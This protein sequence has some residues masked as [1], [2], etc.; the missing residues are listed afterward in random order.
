MLDN[1]KYKGGTIVIQAFILESNQNPLMLCVGAQCSQLQWKKKFTL[2]EEGR[3]VEDF[4]QARRSK[5]DSEESLD[6][7]NIATM[8]IGKKKKLSDIMKDFSKGPGVRRQGMQTT[9]RR[10][11]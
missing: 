6:Q 2:T 10:A 1:N 9:F 5:L 4:V 8:Q 7:V 3:F 11:E